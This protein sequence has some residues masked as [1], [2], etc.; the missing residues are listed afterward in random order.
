MRWVP[1]YEEE[2]ARFFEAR[3]QILSGANTHTR[4]LLMNKGRLEIEF[5]AQYPAMLRKVVELEP[6]IRPDPTSNTVLSRLQQD[7]LAAEF[8]A[9]QENFC[10]A[11]EYKTRLEAALERLPVHKFKCL[12]QCKM[13][14]RQLMDEV[15][16]HLRKKGL[17]PEKKQ[18]ETIP[19]VKYS[20]FQV[21]E[22]KIRSIASKTLWKVERMFFMFVCSR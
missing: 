2:V 8:A 6:S 3:T 18:R 20:E 1:E 21:Q 7:V 12:N 9:E 16:Q 19:Q 4:K 15:Y 11:E 14:I 17:V 13:L 5:E 22:H 10:D